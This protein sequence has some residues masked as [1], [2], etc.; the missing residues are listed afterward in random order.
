MND[1]NINDDINNNNEN[2]TE[3]ETNINII[4]LETLRDNM[5]LENTNKAYVGDC[6]NLLLWVNK[7]EPY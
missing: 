7:N 2:E 1:I 5:V 6:A 3:T 4:T